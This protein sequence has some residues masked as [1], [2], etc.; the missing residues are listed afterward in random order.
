LARRAGGRDL[1]GTR[2]HAVRGNGPLYMRGRIGPCRCGRPMRDSY[3]IGGADPRSAD[4]PG[5]REAGASGAPQAAAA[6][7]PPVRPPAAWQRS[8]SNWTQ[9]FATFDHAFKT[10]VAPPDDGS[11]PPDDGSPPPDDGGPGPGG[12]ALT[13]DLTTN[14]QEL[15]RSSSSLP[16]RASPRPWSRRARRSR[17]P[18]RTSWPTR[19]PRSRRSSS[20]RRE[21][22]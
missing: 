16:P 19:R 7:R 21:T 20:G 8:G 22:G 10:Y 1:S 11:P 12:G 9:G 3:R 5:R 2:H 18:R 17:R 4:R 15:R 13:L 6:L 14:K